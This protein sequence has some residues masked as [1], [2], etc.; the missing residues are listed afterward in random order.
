MLDETESNDKPER[1][2]VPRCGYGE[3]RSGQ[4]EKVH[5]EHPHSNRIGKKWT[6][7]GDAAA[8]RL[9][10]QS[11]T[12]Q[13]LAGTANGTGCYAVKPEGDSR[14]ENVG[15]ERD[16]ITAQCGLRSGSRATVGASVRRPVPPHDR[17][18]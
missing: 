9:L 10:T 3:W 12:P 16:Q 13:A 1:N 4:T 14:Y 6:T 2:C 17:K 18:L 7:P 5:Q 11:G 8:C 15:E